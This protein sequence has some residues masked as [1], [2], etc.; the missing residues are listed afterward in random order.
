MQTL[1]AAHAHVEERDTVSDGA[2]TGVAVFHDFWL[3]YLKT[4]VV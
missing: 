4:A 3:I 1:I 2:G